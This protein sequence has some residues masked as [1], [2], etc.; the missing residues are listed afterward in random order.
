MKRLIALCL[1]LGLLVC[2]M[3]GCPANTPDP[4]P[5]PEPTPT[6]P[7]EPTPD[8]DPEPEPEKIPD[9][10]LVFDRDFT[11]SGMSADLSSTLKDAGVH[12]ARATQAKKIIVGDYESDLADE[13]KAKVNSRTNNYNDFAILCDGKSLAI[14]GTTETATKR[15]LEYLAMNYMF[16]G[17]LAVPTD[18]SYIYQP[19]TEALLL[20]G[21]SV[22]EYTVVY[23]AGNATTQ[24]ELKGLASDLAETLSVLCGTRIPVSATAPAGTPYIELTVRSADSGIVDH[25]VA[26]SYILK[27]TQSGDAPVVSLM[28][29]TRGGLG[30]GVSDFLTL[31]ETDRN[32]P[33]DFNET[34]RIRFQ[35]VAANRTDM[36]KYCGTWQATLA[37]DPTAMVSY[38]NTNYAEISFEGHSI[39]VEFAQSSTFR[40]RIDD[41]EYAASTT[42]SGRVTFF[43]EGSGKHTLRIWHSN[44][45]AHLYIRSFQAEESV[46]LSRPADRAHYIQFIGD[47]ISD[48]G[49]S[50]SHRVGEELGWDYSVIAR[51][52]L[53]L[54]TGRGYYQP[55]A[56]KMCV[57]IA[58]VVKAAYEA[59][60]EKGETPSD[61]LTRLY[62]C[63]Q[64]TT[65][66]VSY[67]NIGMEDAFFKLGLPEDNM[68]GG[69]DEAAYTNEYMTG[70][71]LD[72]QY[73]SG[74]TPDIVF[75]FLGTNDNLNSA[76]GD[77]AFTA[78][79]LRF[80]E[81]ILATY[82][83][84][85]Q[86]CIMNGLTSA[87][88]KVCIR[89][90]AEAIM[91]AH[92][93]NV[94][95]IDSDVLDS[96]N[97]EIS[98]DGT[99][100]TS[101]GYDTLTTKIARLLATSKYYG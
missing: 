53:A 66:G 46:T 92:P 93:D 65:E 81:K 42:S 27:C 56:P 78:T 62:N 83:E 12:P 39:T 90:A 84:D 72:N 13:A 68:I 50:F 14:Y 28:A 48:A 67:L 87:N 88:R 49:N 85:T 77:A 94:K 91:E 17:K 89:A 47:S 20:G 33:L 99:H 36:I 45:N 61:Q 57:N 51:S 76:T 4:T 86:I 9:G 59:K 98:S 69:A 2:A 24:A 75:I 44:R 82:G 31:L 97:V 26:L 16:A 41:G 19:E 40:A 60:V 32:L 70:T 79:Y 54:T 1:L 11:Y 55:N 80:V 100:P 8:P 30:N 35:T 25:K 3:T 10:Y 23:S 37:D 63:L 22:A 21:R 34:R 43:A 101:A 96:W 29:D 71:A 7:P 5:D 6:P 64:T 95:F 38:W 18:L 52:G 15:A 58:T 74:N 73:K